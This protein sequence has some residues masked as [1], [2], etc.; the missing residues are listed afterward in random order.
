MSI[1]AFVVCSC[2]PALLEVIYWNL[3]GHDVVL[4]GLLLPSN[5]FPQAMVSVI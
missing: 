4:S 5:C 1:H 2:R 3:I